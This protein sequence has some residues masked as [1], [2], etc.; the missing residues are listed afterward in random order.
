[1]GLRSDTWGKDPGRKHARVISERDIMDPIKGGGYNTEQ[2][3]DQGGC[4]P[5]MVHSSGDKLPMMGGTK[6]DGVSST[7][8]DTGGS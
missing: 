5:F 1:M 6:R 2:R 7:N 4:S 8:F 3:E